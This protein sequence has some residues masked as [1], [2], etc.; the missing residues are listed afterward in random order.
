MYLPL[1][2]ATPASVGH[3]VGQELSIHERR[4]QRRDSAP[5]GAK[6]SKTRTDNSAIASQRSHKTLSFAEDSAKERPPSALRA[7]HGKDYSRRVT[8][9]TESRGSVEA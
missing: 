2:A 6:L 5:T 3:M 9:E 8:A 4:H 1:S 7:S